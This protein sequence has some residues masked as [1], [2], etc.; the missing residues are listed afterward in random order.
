LFGGTILSLS[1][2]LTLPGC[3][4]LG[5]TADFDSTKEFP[6]PASLAPNLEFWTKVFAEWSRGQVAVHDD[7][8]LGLVYQ[9]ASLPGPVQASYTP[10]QRD[11]VD[12]LKASWRARLQQL[13]RKLASK[14]ALSAEERALRDKILA[15]GG[16]AALIDPADRIRSQRGLRERFHRGLEISGRYDQAFRAIFRRHGVPEDL[17]YLPHVES[18]F[19]LNA[20]SSAGATGVWQ[21][22][23]STARLY[24]TVNNQIDERLDPIIAAEGAARYL[25]EAHQKLGSWPLAIT[26]YNHGVAG[27]GKARALHGDDIGRIVT[28]Y[29]GRYFGFAS[30]NFYAEFLAVR[31]VARHANRYFPEGVRYE[32]PIAHRQQRLTRAMTLSEIAREYNT[33]THAL[34][35]ANPAWLS[36]IRDG[37]VPVPAG[38][39]I[40]LP[41]QQTQARPPRQRSLDAPGFGAIPSQRVSDLP[42]LAL[43]A[44]LAPR[45]MPVP[46]PPCRA[47][48]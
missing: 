32:A 33:T 3:T 30:R 15:A 35:R 27:M 6:I 45:S 4:T 11:F 8:Y 23:R 16:S 31:H 13:S 48:A 40:W 26:S 28:H 21:F 43:A 39:R 42:A 44:G 17:A 12:H 37:R 24:M 20:R 10:R 2:L 34:I 22:I 25:A 38:S 36:P 9:V 14:A 7:R 19:Q 18:S 46:F 5:T 41:A 29:R 47:E 1:L